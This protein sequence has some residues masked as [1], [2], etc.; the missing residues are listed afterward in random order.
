MAILPSPSSW[1]DSLGDPRDGWVIACALQIAVE[2]KD[3]ITTL[4]KKIWAHMDENPAILVFLHYLGNWVVVASAVSVWHRPES[5]RKTKATCQHW[6]WIH[7]AVQVTQGHRLFIRNL[8]HQ[9]HSCIS[10]YQVQML[11]SPR[12]RGCSHTLLTLNNSTPPWI[13]LIR[14]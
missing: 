10:I 13:P 6:N 2:S 4:T 3:T 12:H 11:V 1:Y 7:P 9:H 8:T 14:H 5:I